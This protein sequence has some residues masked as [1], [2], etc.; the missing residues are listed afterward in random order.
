MLRF[1]QKWIVA[2]AS[3]MLL[4]SLGCIGTGEFINPEFLAALGFTGGAVSLPGEAPQVVIELENRTGRVIEGQLTW[5]NSDGTVD[6]RIMVVPTDSKVSEAVFCPVEEMTLGD[7]SNPQATGAVVRLG[8][9][10]PNDPF[11]AVEAFGVILKN[12]VNYSCGDL[13]TFTVQPS[14]ATNSGYQ[15][16][17]FIRRADSSTVVP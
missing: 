11:I 6:E 8:N 17:A 5:R 16:F 14:N 2:S 15:A 1:C 9:G 3:A 4:V 7:V 12:D 13:I 10:G